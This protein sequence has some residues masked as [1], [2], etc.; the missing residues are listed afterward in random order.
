MT[1]FYVQHSAICLI[2]RKVF[3][4]EKAQIPDLLFKFVVCV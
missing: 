1:Q 4:R 2:Y 3:I